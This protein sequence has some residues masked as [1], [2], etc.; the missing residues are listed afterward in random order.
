MRCLWLSHKIFCDL[1]DVGESCGI[2]RVH[3]LMRHEGLKQGDLVDVLAGWEPRSGIVQAVYPSR[4]GM[5]PTVRKLLDFLSDEFALLIA[6]NQGY[7]PSG[8]PMKL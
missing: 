4:R 5:L 3:R 6:A 8:T 2:K 7:I 1:R